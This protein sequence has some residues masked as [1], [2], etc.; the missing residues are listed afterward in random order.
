MINIMERKKRI[1]YLRDFRQTK[2]RKRRNKND[3]DICKLSNH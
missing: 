1:K 3:S 2:K